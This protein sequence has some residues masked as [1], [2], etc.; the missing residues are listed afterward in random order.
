MSFYFAQR[1][2]STNIPLP[3]KIV[4]DVPYVTGASAHQ[5]CDVYMQ[6]GVTNRPV[7]IIFHAGGWAQDR[8]INGAVTSAIQFA[9]A[10]FC[11]VNADYTTVADVGF[12]RTKPITDCQ[13]CV[14]YFRTNAR[15]YNGDPTRIYVLGQSAGGQLGG[16]AAVQGTA[17]ADGSCPDLLGLWSPAI[18]I[19]LCWGTHAQGDAKA[20]MGG[21][22]YPGN[23]SIW[24]QYA[25]GRVAT[26]PICPVRLVGSTNE[27]T[28]TLNG[29]AQQQY[30]NFA[31]QMAALSTPQIVVTRYISS[32]VD[33]VHYQFTG[34]VGQG[35]TAYVTDTLEM[36]NWY[37]QMGGP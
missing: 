14:R 1:S 29:I 35:G 9:L 3:Y 6:Q 32:P 27:N 21:I 26:V 37:Y 24:N 7:L 8:T 15:K 30:I 17:A 19:G 18:D 22:D 2:A 5:M 12:N 34:V 10:G 13:N 28:L 36:A 4:P 23:E 20:Y 25:P 11:V 33:T 16:M 31:A